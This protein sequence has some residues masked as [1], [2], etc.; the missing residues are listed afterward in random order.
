MNSTLNQLR[1]AARALSRTPVFTLTAVLTIALGIGAS[2]AIFS[3][4]NAV[5]LRPLPY[6]DADRLVTI[7]GDL[8]K[9]NV[10][11]FPMPPGD[12]YDLRI[13]GTLF[14]ETAA[15][16]TFRGDLRRGEGEPEMIRAAGVTP[17]LFRTL[18]VRVA[19]GRDFVDADGTPQPAPPE[20]APPAAAPPPL[21]V[22]AILSHESWQNRFGGDREVIGRS[23]ELG[24][25]SAEIV[26]VLE[27][28]VELLFPPAGNVE[29]RPEVYT[30]LRLDLE[31]GNRLNVFL[32]VVGRLK[33]GVSKEQ[34]QAQ[35]DALVV[36]LRRRFPIKETAGLQWRVESM[37]QDLSADAKPTL[38]A[39]MGAVVFV[40]LIA[41]ANV[42]NLLL[43]RASGRERELAVRAALG[44]R[45]ADL[46]RP[47]LLESLLIAIPGAI[48]GVGLA[49][50]GLKLLVAIGPADLPRLDDVSIDTRV[51]GFTA[52]AT[53]AAAVLFG[54][55]PAVRASLVDVGDVLRSGG[56]QPAL[57]GPRGLA[58]AVVIGEVALA[59]VLLVGSGLMA[60]TVLALYRADPGYDPNGVLTF[61]LPNL[62]DRNDTARAAFIQ[63]LKGRIAS[64]PGVIG[65]TAAGPLPLDGD[66]GNNARYGP[67]GAA[68]DPSLF[69]QADMHVVQ[70]GYFEVMR[71]RLLDGRVFTEDDNVQNRRLL[72]IDRVLAQKTFPGQ[73]A[74][75]KQLLT[76][77]GGPQAEMWEVIGVVDHQRH[78]GLGA[79]GREGI[80]V[81][82]GFFGFGQASR[83]VVRTNGNPELLTQPVRSTIKA[84]DPSM[85]IA[86]LQPYDVFISAAR[87]PAKFALVLIGIFAGIAAV[88]ATVGLYGVLATLV[89]QR[90]AEIGVRM[91]FGAPRASILRLIVG[92]GLRLSA[93]GIV[94]G[95][96]AAVGMT[97][98]LDS[99]LVGVG[100]TDPITFGAIILLFVVIAALACWIPARRAAGLDPNA[101][102]H[103]E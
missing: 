33:P 95:V 25:Q 63:D 90:T 86:D 85:A 55:F 74:V 103:S 34:A 41:C 18:G 24:G 21:P 17:N 31:N 36:D 83:W 73:S 37:H 71:T 77:V 97:R 94:I 62:G 16:V 45:R 43:V 102:L 7:W 54:L 92:R 23:V 58:H 99:M 1:Y 28:D 4:M 79:D 89:R 13:Q 66:G 61:Q 96:A 15:V 57:A 72:I 32:R 64:L 39:L 52:L 40:L 60:R 82:D 42:A 50:G 10:T 3:V 47:V 100:A 65:V 88:L 69:Q 26:G 22:V 68:S 27:P 98:V 35:I 46:L 59:F 14:E 75:G 30:A 101:A 19:L 2:T 5:L 56:R 81:T 29:R 53:F 91:A 20:G 38:T 51:L 87:A 84:L 80:F 8:T 76:R 44:G 12:L 70:P 11:D 48:L 9:R 67:E 93:L 78:T 6:R 49:I